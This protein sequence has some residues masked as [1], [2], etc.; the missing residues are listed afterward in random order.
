MKVVSYSKP[1]Y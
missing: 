1:T